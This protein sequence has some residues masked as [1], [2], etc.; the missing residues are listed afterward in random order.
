[1]LLSPRQ[2]VRGRDVLWSREGF[3]SANFGPVNVPARHCTAA[4]ERAASQPRS[5]QDDVRAGAGLQFDGS[6]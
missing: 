3:S 1:M 4:N 5:Q 2:F 6:Y